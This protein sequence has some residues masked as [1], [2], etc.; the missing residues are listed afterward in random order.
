MVHNSSALSICSDA[1]NANVCHHQIYASSVA[2][3]EDRQV[4]FRRRYFYET[5]DVYI[6]TTMQDDNLEFQP[7]DTFYLSISLFSS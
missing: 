3:L 7:T 6:C 2:K 5:T 1:F 4:K